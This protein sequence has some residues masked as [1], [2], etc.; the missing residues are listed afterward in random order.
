MEAAPDQVASRLLSP[1]ASGD[2]PSGWRYSL[3]HK[4][5]RAA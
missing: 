3:V 2:Q 4:R 5:V 1:I